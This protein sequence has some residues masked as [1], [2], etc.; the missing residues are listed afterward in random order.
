VSSDATPIISAMSVVRAPWSSAS[1]LHYVGVFIVLA[2]T[3]SL[4]SSL[5]D[6]YGD[7]AFVAWSLL[8]LVLVAAFA[9][10]Y[11]AMGMPLVAGL[12]AVITLVVFVI[13]VG[14]FFVWI[15]LLGHNDEPIGGFHIGLLLLYLIGFVASLSLLARYHFP[16]LVLPAAAF[17]WIF[18]IDLLSNGGTWTAVLAILVGLVFML[19]GAGLD[20]WYG[21]WMH[22]AAGLSIGVAF[23]YLWHHA[24]WEWILIG[25]VALFFFLFASA[26]D[27]SS[28]TV[29]GAIGLFLVATHFIEDWVGGISAPFFFEGEP[30]DHPWARALLYALF[31]FILLAFGLWFQRRRPAPL[32]ESPS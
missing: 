31:G 19:V 12:F 27:R 10:G 18:W 23:L 15:H 25:V 24:W 13:F 4:L 9:A 7:F 2:A 32:D 30:S 20:R 8:V 1:F 21:F 16:L 17:A 22:V 11:Q 3:V 29:L 28:Y 14:A 26:F 6:D 5:A